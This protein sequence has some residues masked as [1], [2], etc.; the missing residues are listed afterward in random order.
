MLAIVG[1]EATTIE[2]I[3]HYLTNPE[4]APA[5]HSF[6]KKVVKYIVKAGWMFKQTNTGHPLLVIFDSTKRSKLLERVH[7][8]LGHHGN[9]Y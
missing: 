4:P 9:A 1:I 3:F 6:L 2:D 7:E 8:L 5:S